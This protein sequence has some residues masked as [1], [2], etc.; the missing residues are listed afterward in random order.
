M[1]TVRLSLEGAWELLRNGFV[2]GAGL[3]I[4]FALG[5]RL[6]SGSEAAAT[7]GT[8]TASEPSIGSR[9]AAVVCFLLVVYAVVAG[10]EIIVAAGLG[11]V[12]T[13]DHIIP[14]LT[15]KD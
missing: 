7:D 15:P 2:L 3:P 11:K 4:I 13:F 8:A 1:D 12:V 9:I 5:V 10:I 14:T 6:W